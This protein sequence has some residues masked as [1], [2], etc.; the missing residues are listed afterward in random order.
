MPRPKPVTV[1]FG[2]PIMFELNL[3]N[4]RG[5][6]G[7]RRAAVELLEQRIRELK[8]EFMSGQTVWR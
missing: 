2:E 4:P 8:R 6:R 1:R 5:G 7:V 3:L